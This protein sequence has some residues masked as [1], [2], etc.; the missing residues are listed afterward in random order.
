MVITPL[1]RQSKL[2]E[3]PC[4]ICGAEG[5]ECHPIDSTRRPTRFIWLCKRHQSQARVGDC[6]WKLSKLQKEILKRGL[7]RHLLRAAA[8]ACRFE[9]PGCFHAKEIGLSDE[10]LEDRGKVA[11]KRA[12]A[13][14]SIA[15]L[16]NRGLV[17]NCA[18]GRWRLTA[19]GLK[20]AR[21]LYPEVK[22]LPK[23]EL[24]R[25]IKMGIAMAQAVELGRVDRIREQLRE[26]R[27]RRSKDYAAK[28]ELL[29]AALEETVKR[30]LA[31]SAEQ[32]TER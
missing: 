28:L 10:D 21:Q 1:D 6:Y 16:I 32:S 14:L 15:R 18:R 11:A 4:E 19:R 26:R 17:K 23:K 25:N 2:K 24:A 20:V 7:H 30:R 13:G 12:A 29:E 3:K 31:R 9:H 22:K 27:L 5:A 8:L